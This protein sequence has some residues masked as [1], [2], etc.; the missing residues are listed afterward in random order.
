MATEHVAA[1]G[2]ALAFEYWPALTCWIIPMLGAVLM[3]VF[4]KFGDKFRDMMAVVF[5]AG[6]AISTLMMVPWLLSGHTPG[7]LQFIRLDQ[8]LRTLIKDGCTS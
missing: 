8:L 5:G 1:A 4:A 6:A 3:P 7:D 2:W